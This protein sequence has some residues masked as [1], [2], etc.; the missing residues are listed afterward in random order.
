M[1]KIDN[2]VDFTFPSR[3]EGPGYVTKDDGQMSRQAGNTEC[4]S[5]DISAISLRVR[6]VK[7][8]NMNIVSWK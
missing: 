7:S 6:V 5:F 4:S 3:R 8:A 2:L 1:K